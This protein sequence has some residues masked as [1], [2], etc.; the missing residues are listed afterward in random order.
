MIG[1]LATDFETSELCEAFEVSRSGYY[2]WRK[3]GR[4]HRA[5]ANA[6][7]GKRIEKIH[8]QSRSNYGCPRIAK[9]LADQGIR[10]SRGRVARI[11]RARGL[12]GVQK[13]RFRPKTTD[14]RHDDPIAPN[15][16]RDGV[17]VTGPNQV[18]VSDITY[19]PTRERW[20]YLAA[21]MD[22]G[23]RVVK[24]WALQDSLKS[25]LVVKAFLQAVFRHKPGAGLIVHS[26]RGCQYASATFRKHLLAHQAMASMGR[27][28][29]CYDNA[30]MESFWAT[31]K[32]ELRITRPYETTEDARLAI[33]DY[34]ETFYNRRRLHSAIGYQTPLNFEA[35]FM[36]GV[37]CPHVSANSR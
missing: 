3:G 6:E 22:L 35:Q 2:A 36:A 12:K 30:T 18:W 4:G 21:F 9:E 17:E 33:F 8:E 26:D 1:E 32:A 24:G 23:T 25:D 34:I 20:M 15:R 10:C 29:N 19:I 11:M 28:G 31:L 7:L 27:T 14:S 37:I 13:G 16:L 5:R